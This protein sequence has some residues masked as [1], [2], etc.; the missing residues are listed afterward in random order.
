MA[1]DVDALGY[2]LVHS[3]GTL[4]VINAVAW[5]ALGEYLAIRAQAGP[6]GHRTVPVT[7]TVPRE[8]VADLHTRLGEALAEIDT[9]EVPRQ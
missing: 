5:D 9:A 1:T 3:L 2:E 8:L 6:V 7:W 4:R